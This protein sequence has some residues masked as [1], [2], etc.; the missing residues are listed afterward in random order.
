MLRDTDSK[1]QLAGI[2]DANTCPHCNPDTYIGTVRSTHELPMRGGDR[3][4]AA[5]GESQAY[6][7]GYDAEEF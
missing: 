3:A 7:W 4:E 6:Q 5:D 1:V 2:E